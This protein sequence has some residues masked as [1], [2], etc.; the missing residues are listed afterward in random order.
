MYRTGWW[1]SR[2]R[3]R[4]GVVACL[5]TAALAGCAAGK[6]AQVTRLQAQSAYERGLTDLAEGRTS[7][8]LAALQEA[9]QLDPSVPLYHNALGLLYINLKRQPDAL[10]AFKRAVELDGNYGEAQHNLGVAYAEGGRWEEAIRAYRRALSLPGYANQEVAYHNLGWAYF[11]VGRLQ[12]AEE[13]FRLVLRI[14]PNMASAHYQLGLVLLKGG[15]RDGAKAAFRRARE[16]APDTPFGLAA[17]EHLKALGE[18]G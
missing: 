6:A 8:G 1:L 17:Q 7:L 5:V 10:E 16:L 4:S 3:G 9:A 11:N 12:E 13:S 15:R 2:F 14:D 18:G